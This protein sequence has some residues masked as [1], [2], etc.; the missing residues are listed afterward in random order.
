MVKKTL[1]NTAAFLF[2]WLAISLLANGCVCVVHG[3]SGREP[4]TVYV[5]SPPPPPKH[6]T[7]TSAPSSSH[8]WV[9]GHWDYNESNDNWEWEE[10]SW[11]VPPEGGSTWKKP[12]Y[13]E[14]GGKQVYKPGR[15]KKTD[16]NKKPQKKNRIKEGQG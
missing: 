4:R 3:H 16:K 15:W 6:E 12:E 11:E 14:H 7:K 10:G 8:V 9:E 5:K 13:E 2:V 1:R